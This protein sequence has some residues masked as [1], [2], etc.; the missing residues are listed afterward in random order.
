MRLDCGYKDG[1]DVSIAFDPML[2]K[3]ISW[4]ENRE[5]ASKKMV[6]ALNEVVFLGEGIKTNRNYLQRILSL[7]EFQDGK[8]FT[9]FV[10][11]YKEKLMP[12]VPTKEE[13][14]MAIARMLL[15]RT[16]EN[17]DTK[18]VHAGPWKSLIGFRSI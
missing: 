4:G 8:T 7:K 1:N 5:V 3:L 16:S 15:T 2:A 18:S 14:A 11:T 13:K 9:H 10:T 17:T 12:K 6:L